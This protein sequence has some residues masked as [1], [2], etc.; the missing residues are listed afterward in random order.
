MPTPERPIMDV[1]ELSALV[2]ARVPG[3][4]GTLKVR[5]NGDRVT[6]IGSGPWMSTAFIEVDRAELE[7]ALDPDRCH[8]RKGHG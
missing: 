5:V 8:G 1:I 2:G 7:R 4:S 3:E 6:L